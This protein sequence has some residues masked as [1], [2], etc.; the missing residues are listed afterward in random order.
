[1][2]AILVF[3]ILLVVGG[4][5]FFLYQRTSKRKVL[6]RY[7]ERPLFDKGDAIMFGRLCRALP[8]C[9]IFPHLALSAILEPVEGN[10]ANHPE[11]YDLIANLTVDFAVY[12]R[13][14]GLICV[15]NMEH[16]MLDL[17][18]QRNPLIERCLRRAEI[19]VV[20]YNTASKPSVEQIGR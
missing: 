6:P 13:D 3:V 1:M 10:R 14:L 12:N 9:Y 2:N 15:V 18:S 16:A 19:N 17:G 8:D 7:E 4:V 20:R 5:V 11:R